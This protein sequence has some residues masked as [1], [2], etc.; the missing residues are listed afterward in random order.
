MTDARF[1]PGA[2]LQFRQPGPSEIGRQ[3]AVIEDRQDRVLVRP[4][5]RLSLEM[6]I[7]PTHVYAT[8]DME[9][10]QCAF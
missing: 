10:V 4:I 6:A 7:T 5:D 3:F 9:L 8:A 2:I 1:L